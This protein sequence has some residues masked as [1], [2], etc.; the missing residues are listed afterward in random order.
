MSTP[1]TLLFHS[2]VFVPTVAQP[3]VFEGS[4]RY[5]AHALREAHSDRYGD[6]QLPDEFH[7][8]NAKLIES[9][10][11]LESNRIVKQVWRQPLDLGR[12]LVLVIGE[13]GVVRTVWVNLHSDKHRSLDRSKYTSS[14][15]WRRISAVANAES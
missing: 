1:N 10:L 4:L 9:E 2:E 7:C 12:D 13:Q 6:I 14:R 5:S 3:P 15:A 8:A 11:L